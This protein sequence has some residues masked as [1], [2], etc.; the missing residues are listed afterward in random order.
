M[1]GF[2]DY[3][4]IA[5]RLRSILAGETHQPAHPAGPA[6]AA[7][8]H[9]RRP[10]RATSRARPRRRPSTSAPGARDRAARRAPPAR[11]RPDGAAQAG[12]RLRPPLHVLRDPELPRLVRLPPALRRARRGAL[13]GRPGRARA[14]PGQRELHVLRQ[15]PRRPPA[16][17]DAAAR[18]GRA[19]TAWS[20]CGSP[21]SSRPRPARPGRRRSPRPPAWR[22][23]STSPSSTPSGPVLRRMRRFGDSES[24]LGL[25]DQVRGAGARGRRPLQ[26][27]RRL[28]R[29]DRGRPR[30][31]CATSSRRPG[32]TRSASS[33]TPTRT[34]PRPRV[35][36]QARR[37]R[38]PRPGRARHRAR[39]GAHRP[40]GRGAHRRAASR[41]SWSRS[42]DGEVVEGRGRA[43]GSRGRR[44][45]DA[46]AAATVRRSVTWSAPWSSHR[47]RRPGRDVAEAHGA[48]R[49]PMSRAE[50]GR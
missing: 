13:A 43:P 33:A 31:R 44:V 46:A 35:R 18:A 19:S 45:D 1:L 50:P 14:V 28:P 11:R 48:E 4:D 41:C 17:R 29:R 2:D 5:D 9:P 21:T 36:R 25:L 7:A 8:D 24:F 49:G 15:G 23:T 40:A 27:H 34:A 37:G 26:L 20:G 47:R 16:A 3:P 32:W 10:R 12:L 22:R 39:R 38:D 30:D 6:P 42:T